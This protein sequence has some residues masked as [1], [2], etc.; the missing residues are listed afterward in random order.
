MLVAQTGK[1][2]WK[3][4]KQTQRAEGRGVS[5]VQVQ[6]KAKGDSVQFA[7][8][9][10]QPTHSWNVTGKDLIKFFLKNPVQRLCVNQ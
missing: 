1:R 3:L 7:E 6:L 5:T 10:P 2:S 8:H 4:D 9:S